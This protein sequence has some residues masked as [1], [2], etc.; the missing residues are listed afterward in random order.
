MKSNLISSLAFISN[1][2]ST[3]Q[4]PKTTVRFCKGISGIYDQHALLSFISVPLA[5][6]LQKQLLQ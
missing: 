2:S 3:R 6:S 5:P 1:N 4:F